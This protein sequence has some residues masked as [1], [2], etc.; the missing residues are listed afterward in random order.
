ML[1]G[2]VVGVK[3][4]HGCVL[5]TSILLLFTIPS[6]K[7]SLLVHQVYVLFYSEHALLQSWLG[8]RT[9]NN[10]IDSFPCTSVNDTQ[11]CCTHLVPSVAV[12]VRLI[13]GRIEE[14]SGVRSSSHPRWPM[15]T[16]LVSLPLLL[17]ATQLLVS[18]STPSSLPST[19]PC[20]SSLLESQASFPCHHS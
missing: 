13:D 11:H 17:M 8:L 9:L 2:W 4:L 6:Q 20:R 18:W 19:G 15:W 10:G 5:A 16:L 3:G 7:S 14:L 12:R 1:S